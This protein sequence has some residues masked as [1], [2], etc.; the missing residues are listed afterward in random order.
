MAASVRVMWLRA[1]VRY[2]PDRSLV[3][4][5]HFATKFSLSFKRMF[6]LTTV[7][8]TITLT[9][10]IIKTMFGNQNPTTGVNLTMSKS[11]EDNSNTNNDNNNSRKVRS[12]RPV[13]RVYNLSRVQRSYSVYRT[14]RQKLELAIF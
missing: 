4:V 5:C 2:W 11:Q 9:I 7:M 13:Q 12:V 14:T 1:C 3:C 8:I 10:M 6:F